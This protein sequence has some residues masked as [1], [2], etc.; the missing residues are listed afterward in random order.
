MPQTTLTLS[1]LNIRIVLV[2]I[3][4]E[5]QLKQLYS[6]DNT[7]MVSANHFEALLTFVYSMDTGNGAMS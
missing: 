3:S 1:F 7:Q 5:K 4:E 6:K 2:Y